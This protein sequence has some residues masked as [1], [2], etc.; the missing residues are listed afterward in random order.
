MGAAGFAI[1]T[2]AITI[3][4]LS[5]GN[6]SYSDNP[7]V[8][9]FAKDNYE[10]EAINLVEELNNNGTKAQFSVLT[11]LEE[12]NAFAEKMGIKYVRVVG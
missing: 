5:D 1:D 8:L 3:K 4:R 2:D 12:T 10:I 9:V 11:T 6:V 7:E